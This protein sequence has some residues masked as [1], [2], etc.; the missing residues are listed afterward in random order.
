M[1]ITA[2]PEEFAVMKAESCSTLARRAA[3]ASSVSSGVRVHVVEVD[4]DALGQPD[5]RERKALG[6]KAVGAGAV[7]PLHPLE[8]VERVVREGVEP[9]A[10]GHTATGRRAVRVV[11]ARVQRRV[12]VEVLLHV[13]DVVRPETRGEQRGVHLRVPGAQQLREARD[14]VRE[15]VEAAGGGGGGSGGGRD[16]GGEPGEGQR[17]GHQGTDESSHGGGVSSRRKQRGGSGG[18]AAEP[19]DAGT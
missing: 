4:E 3:W 5:P 2:L 11:V 14:V 10:E 17:A 16:G 7:V 15:D 13:D 18:R 12:V 8:V 6:R 9:V 19:E 1:T